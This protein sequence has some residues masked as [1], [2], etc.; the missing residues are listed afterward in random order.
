MTSASEKRDLTMR[1]KLMNLIRNKPG[2]RA[3]EVPLWL[4]KWLKPLEVEGK[5]EYRDPTG[6]YIRIDC[7]DDRTPARHE[8]KLYC[9]ACDADLE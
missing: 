6:W 8:G 9:E 7:C 2:I 3:S 1:S 4:I 5:I